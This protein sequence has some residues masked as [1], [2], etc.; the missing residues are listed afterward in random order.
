VGSGG[1]IAMLRCDRCGR[2]EDGDRA[3]DEGWWPSYWVTPTIRREEPV[4]PEC[5][6]EHLEGFDEEPIL[7]DGHLIALG[8]DGWSP[9]HG[10]RKALVA[11]IELC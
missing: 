5:A 3:I 6:R 4:W 2:I 1:E 11:K 9:V 10:T 8:G 7:K